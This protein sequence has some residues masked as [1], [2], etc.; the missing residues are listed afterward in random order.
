LHDL[1][2]SF[3]SIAAAGKASLPIIGGLLGHTQ[4]ATTARYVHL[5]ADPLKATVG[6]VGVVVDAAMKGKKQPTSPN[7]TKVASIADRRRR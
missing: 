4:P 1:R 3:A 7:R 5:F 6:A 2:H